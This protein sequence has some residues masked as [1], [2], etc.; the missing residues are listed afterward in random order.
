VCCAGVYTKQFSKGHGVLCP[1]NT[2]Q[3]HLS[4]SIQ[5]K[6]HSRKSFTKH[7]VVLVFFTE[8]FFE[9][10]PRCASLLCWCLYKA[11]CFHGWKVEDASEACYKGITLRLLFKTALYKHQHS[12]LAQLGVFSKNCSVKTQAQHA[13]AAR[14]LFKNCSVY[15]Y[16]MTNNTLCQS[17]EL[18]TLCPVGIMKTDLKISFKNL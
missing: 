15:K 8:H 10:T 2:L 4:P 18:L 7:D 3:R 13:C 9:K 5:E 16:F 1:Y 12:T 14:Y 17:S 6:H 11:G